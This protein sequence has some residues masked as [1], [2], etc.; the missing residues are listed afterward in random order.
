[1]YLSKN[2]KIPTIYEKNFVNKIFYNLKFEKPLDEIIC[3]E[4]ITADSLTPAV[5]SPGY[6]ESPQ[7]HRPLIG[8]LLDN[9][10]TPKLSG[11]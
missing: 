8:V 9:P 5:P 11:F 4:T 6:I 10:N 3:L 2:L 1:M 7:S